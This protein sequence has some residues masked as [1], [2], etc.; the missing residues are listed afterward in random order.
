VRRA[1]GD[2]VQRERSAASPGAGRLMPR[3]A[4]PARSGNRQCRAQTTHRP[5][6]W[7]DDDFR[8]QASLM[9]MDS[10][11]RLR[12]LQRAC[13]ENPQPSGNA[14]RDSAVVAG[15]GRRFTIGPRRVHFSSDLVVI[16]NARNCDTSHIITVKNFRTFDWEVHTAHRR[17]PGYTKRECVVIEEMDSAAAIV[18]SRPTHRVGEPTLTRREAEVAQLVSQGLANKAVAGQLGLQEGTVKLHLHNIYR[19]LRVPNRTGLIH[20]LFAKNA[21]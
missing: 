2:T 10:P 6:R 16:A 5:R 7:I 15:P 13:H 11:R 20:S 3:G 9:P 8:P 21:E 1:E 12:S 14:L 18:D 19:K 17:E 4:T